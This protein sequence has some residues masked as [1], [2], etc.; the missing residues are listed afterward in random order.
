MQTLAVEGAVPRFDY[1]D[2]R[3]KVASLQKEIA[4]QE[5]TIRQ[6]EQSHQAANKSLNRLKA[7][8]QSEILTQIEKQEQDLADLQGRLSQ[9]REQQKGNTIR[10]SVSGTVYNIKVTKA[11]SLVHSGDELLSI[12]PDAEE[13][14]VEAKVPNQDIGFV[15]H[16]MKA[17]VKLATFPYQEYGMLEGTVSKISPNAVN[18]KDAGLV[19]PVQVKLKQRSVLVNGQHVQLTPGMATTAEIVTRQKT[20]LSFLLDPITASWD[21]GFSVG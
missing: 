13:L 21:R 6:A 15:R 3:N 20:V 1:F 16:Q 19:F 2:T 9:A 8:R 7:E 14:L 10:S 4:I 11:G 12:A 18:E 17:K 5:Q